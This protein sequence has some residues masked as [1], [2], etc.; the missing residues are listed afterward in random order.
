ME[1]FIGKI[2]PDV[3]IQTITDLFAPYG[4]TNIRVLDGKGCAFADLD[5]LPDAE[6]AIKDLNGYQVGSGPGLNVKP[7]DSKSATRS[8]SGGRTPPVPLPPGPPLRKS[9]HDDAPQA[10]PEVFIGRLSPG[11]IHDVEEALFSYGAQN[12]RLLDGSGCAF[13]AFATWAAAERAIAE[14][15]GAQFGPGG[16]LE[17]LNVK[18]ADAKGAPKGTKKDPKVFIG[19]LHPQVTEDEIR[20][21]CSRFGQ[22]IH[23]KIFSRSTGSPPCAF[24]TFSSFTEAEACINKVNGAASLLSAEGKVLVARFADMTKG[25]SQQHRTPQA[26][27][28]VFAQQQHSCAMM[29][30]PAAP[31]GYHSAPLPPATAYRDYADPNFGNPNRPGSDDPPPSGGGVG[32]KVFIGG[33]PQEASEDFIWGMMSTF[34]RV[35]EVKVLRKTGAKPCGFARFAQ[36]GDAEQAIA[37]LGQG[38][39]AVKYAD[40]PK[41]TKRSAAAAFGQDV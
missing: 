25:V 6:R 3:G 18:F 29:A 15:N 33:L 19:G 38:R 1:V 41:G 11:I 7:A 32:P 40:D 26:S 30:L 4:A 20:G 21:E 27:A 23:C 8:S 12:V 37:A 17:G 14:L 39:F 31:R 24:V 35:A 10:C 28:P 36:I 34:G 9:T 2:P 16:Q 5:S 22:I 13:A